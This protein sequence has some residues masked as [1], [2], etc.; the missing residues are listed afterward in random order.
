MAGYFGSYRKNE[1]PDAPEVV[2]DDGGSGL[3]QACLDR[4]AALGCE[5][6]CDAAH[7]VWVKRSGTGHSIGLARWMVERKPMDK[8]LDGV[9]ERLSRQAVTT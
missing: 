4:F 2:Y 6:V 1:D 3:Y 9:A 5:I 7:T 8:L